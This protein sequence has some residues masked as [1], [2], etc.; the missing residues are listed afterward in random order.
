MCIL[1]VS[2]SLSA[3]RAALLSLRTSV[4][5]YA[6]AAI[7]V[8]PNAQ[9][10]VSIGN[11]T[12]GITGVAAATPPTAGLAYVSSDAADAARA[13]VKT[14]AY[15][16][17]GQIC[18]YLPDSTTT[19]F[20]KK[21]LRDGHYWILGRA[22]LLRSQGRDDGRLVQPE[23]RHARRPGHGGGGAARGR[24]HHQGRH[25]HRQRPALRDERLA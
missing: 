19:S 11:Q 13:T 4:G 12:A 10:G 17:K 24:R 8:H 5:L 25:R 22:E 7:S 18:G 1:R 15:Q 3:A 9:K 20:D 21:N 23:R 16:H 6:G 2:E 14:L